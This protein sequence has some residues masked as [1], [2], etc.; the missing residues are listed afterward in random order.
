[1]KKAILIPVL[2]VTF[3]LG[4]A[5]SD[6]LLQGINLIFGDVFTTPYQLKKELEEAM[7]E[8]RKKL[9]ETQQKQEEAREKYDQ[10]SGQMTQKQANMNSLIKELDTKVNPS[11]IKDILLTTPSSETGNKGRVFLEAP[12]GEALLEPTTTDDPTVNEFKKA[13]N[14]KAKDIIDIS[15]GV[16]KEKIGQLNKELVR[17]NDELKDRNIELIGKLREIA[18]YK[19]EVDRINN[20]LADKNTK[21]EAKLKE[22]EQYKAELEEHKKTI[23]ALEGIKSNLEK[24][25]GV[26]ET[27]I[28]DGRLKVSFKGDILFESGKH[29]LR[30]EG[31]ELLD[32]VY[33]I[34]SKSTE[35][36]DIFIAGHTDNVPIRPDAR[37]KYESNW[38]LSTYR[39]IEVV[40]YLVDKGIAPRSLTAA[41][42]G[43]YKP[44]A[45]NSSDEGKAKNRRVELFL[46]PKIIKR[47]SGN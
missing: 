13:F 29:Q 6:L 11:V 23:T 21:L 38:T 16:L 35:Q 47:Q 36:N 34:L 28:E 43:E 3:I 44:V 17:I 1:M 46:I 30:E 26:L 41:G 4:I 33:S 19:K 25:V 39:A 2:V 12:I 24:T 14:K 5:L 18:G 42:Y 7:E 22:V 40:K 45:D 15:K 37:D 31:K 20:E 27:K 10:L 8:C 9:A 32:S